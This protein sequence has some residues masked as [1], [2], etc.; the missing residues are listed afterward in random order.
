MNPLIFSLIW[1]KIKPDTPTKK[2]IW[3]SIIAII[4]LVLSFIL[5]YASHKPD[6]K[7]ETKIDTQVQT[8]VVTQVQT[9]IEYQ[10]RI[11]EKT[12]YVKVQD[13]QQHTH[14]DLQIIKNKDG[15]EIITEHTSTGSETKTDVDKESDKT[16]TVQ[17][18]TNQTV[19]QTSTQKVDQKLSQVVTTSYSPNWHFGVQ[20]GFNFG[21]ASIKSGQFSPGPV[22]LG[23]DAER[24]IIGPFWGGV[25]G[26]TQK[27]AGITL[28]LEF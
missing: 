19:N 3:A 9:K 17:N 7:I 18:N 2:K 21:Q 12:V 22:V 25:W 28:G 13:T 10:D 24:K 11:V 20:A 26:N 4:L 15:S 23:L 14:K 5:G 16:Q 6:T 1:S 27:N 8:K